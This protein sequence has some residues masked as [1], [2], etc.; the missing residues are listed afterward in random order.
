MRATRANWCAREGYEVVYDCGSGD[1]SHDG[2][3][4]PAFDF[5]VFTVP[6]RVGWD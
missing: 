4:I 3:V 2:G 1:A 5:E 6:V